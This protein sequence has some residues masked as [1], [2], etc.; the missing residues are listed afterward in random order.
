MVALSQ[1]LQDQTYKYYANT[2]S[3]ENQFFLSVRLGIWN[4]D[5]RLNRPPVTLKKGVTVE[6]L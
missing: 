6:F 1:I 4:F 2:F 5:Q 3:N